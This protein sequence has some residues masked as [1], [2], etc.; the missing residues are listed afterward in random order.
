MLN[1]SWISTAQYSGYVWVWK[2]SYGQIQLMGT[3]NQIRR[4]SS[5]HSEL[6]ALG[7]MIESML[8]RSTCKNF[9]SDY[10][11]LISMI[12]EQHA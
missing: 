7:W 1:G 12:E 3:K 10:K 11:D 2:D 9:G 5:L 4:V 6:E 8:R